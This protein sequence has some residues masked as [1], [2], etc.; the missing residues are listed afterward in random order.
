MP[1]SFF[2]TVVYG[3]RI[4]SSWFWPLVD[5][6]FGPITPSTLKTW[7]R[8]RISAPV[9]SSSPKRFCATFEPSVQTLAVLRTSCSLKKA[10]AFTGQ[11]LMST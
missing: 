7:L 8:I 5:A 4:W 6:P 2:I 10:P 1:C 3:A 11:D 9:G